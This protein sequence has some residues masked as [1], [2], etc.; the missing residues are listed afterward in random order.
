MNSDQRSVF[1]KAAYSVLSGD[2]RRAPA[3]P[4]LGEAHSGGGQKLS[5]FKTIDVTEDGEV[6]LTTPDGQSVSAPLQ[7]DGIYSPS[8]R[9]LAPADVHDAV[10]S[11]AIS[12][13]AAL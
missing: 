5:A 1:Q 7:S 10:Y 9:P 3:D 2:Q 12:A 8:N 4:K 11:A 6:V 13:A